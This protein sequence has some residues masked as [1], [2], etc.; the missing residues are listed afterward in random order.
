M[1]LAHGALAFADV[2]VDFTLLFSHVRGVIA[3]RVDVSLR[4]VH[5]R[6]VRRKAAVVAVNV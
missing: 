1:V 2:G 4:I 5:E 6:V 3:E